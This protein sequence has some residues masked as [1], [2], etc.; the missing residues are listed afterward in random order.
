MMIHYT[1]LFVA[2][3]IVLAEAL[4]KIERTDPFEPGL[5]ARARAVVWLKMIGWCCIAMGAAGGI[6]RPMLGHPMPSAGESL[7]LVGF[8]LLVVRSRLGECVQSAG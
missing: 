4:N 5:C 3:V 8:A 1:L 6:V 2:G 7:T